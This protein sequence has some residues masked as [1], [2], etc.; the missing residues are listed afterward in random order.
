MQ[1]KVRELYEHYSGGMEPWQI[2][3]AI[4]RLQHFNVPQ[5][6]W[7]DT[8]QELAIVVHQFQ[9]DADK[10]HA[11]TEETILCRRM[12]NCIRMLARSDRRWHK[13]HERLA[14]L[15]HTEEDEQTPDEIVD[16]REVVA[17]VSEV[18]AQLPRELQ[19]I[20]QRLIDGQSPRR[21]SN[22]TGRAWDTI[23]RQMR[24]VREMLA[25][26]GIDSWPA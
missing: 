19:D 3:L 11:A 8:M 23:E 9:F 18:L 12:D 7:D 15:R 5:R 6:A 26:R 10:A 2:K 13:T 14:E 17:I 21:I 25:E 1:N 22:E 4:A 16:K 20:C 24:N